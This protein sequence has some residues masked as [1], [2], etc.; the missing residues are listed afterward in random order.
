MALNIQQAIDQYGGEDEAYKNKLKGHIREAMGYSNFVTQL[1]GAV[2]APIDVGNIE[3]LDP[4]AIARRRQSEQGMQEQKVQSLESNVQKIDSAA[5][6]LASGQVSR[7]KKEADKYRYDTNFTYN[8][9][10]ELD[11]KILEYAQ[12]PYNEDGSIKSL[13]QFESELREQYKPT[14]T[15]ER[16]DNM[17]LTGEPQLPFEFG[18]EPG[19]YSYDDIK[20][21]I[22]ERLP[23]DYIGKE[24]IYAYRFQGFDEKSAT[25]QTILSYGDLILSGQGAKVP[26][27]LYP[28]A[29]ATLTPSEQSRV[30]T[31]SFVESDGVDSL[32]DGLTD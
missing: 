12:N 31:G 8:P 22:V 21:R 23:G 32:L 6:V 1:K 19:K 10:D 29:Y 2:N 16:V 14:P 4:A 28:V 9:V 20:N 24:N 25:E 27:E 11:Q 13:Q 30:R 3:D 17:T 7:E 5:D 26:K 18:E 15:T